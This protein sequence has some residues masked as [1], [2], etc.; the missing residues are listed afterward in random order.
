M[1]LCVL[2]GSEGLKGK[3]KFYA[4]KHPLVGLL[5]NPV[6][7][8]YQ[9]PRMWECDCPTVAGELDLGVQVRGE[10]CTILRQLAVPIIRDEEFLRFGILC[11]MQ[12][13]KDKFW[14]R[15]AQ[16]WLYGVDRT[17]VSAEIAAMVAEGFSSSSLAAKAAAHTAT[18]VEI[19]SMFPHDAR[20]A[21]E[22]ARLANQHARID[23]VDLAHRAISEEAPV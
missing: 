10:L 2:T 13:F 22:S 20:L 21:V 11:A 3:K 8:D 17:S 16:E 4:F 12:V 14:L 18:A 9:R 23:L 1:R 15:W 5:L 7:S 19:A 6:C